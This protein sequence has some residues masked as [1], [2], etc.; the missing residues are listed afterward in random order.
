MHCTWLFIY[1]SSYKDSV[2]SMHGLNNLTGDLG[3]LQGVVTSQ[4]NGHIIM[5]K[6]ELWYPMHAWWYQFQQMIPI[7]ADSIIFTPFFHPHPLHPPQ[8]SLF[9]ARKTTFVVSYQ[10]P[11]PLTLK[12]KLFLRCYSTMHWRTVEHSHVCWDLYVN[13]HPLWE[14]AQVNTI[15]S[16]L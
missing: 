13:F 16:W 12:L 1:G 10:Y 6:S 8:K 11:H 15:L 14:W 4:F 2:Y 5:G 3:L 7:T 9:L